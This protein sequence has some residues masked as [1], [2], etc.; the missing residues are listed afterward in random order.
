MF[1]TVSSKPDFVK[2][3]HRILDWWYRSGLVEKYLQKNNKAKK[4]F[5]FFDGPIT[6][7]NPMG[8]HHAWGRT[9]KDLFQ[10]YKNM[11]GYRE[12]FQNGFDCQGLWVEVEVEK[13]AGFNSKKDIEKYGVDKF[14]KACLARVDKYANIQTEQSKR[15]GMFMDWE[16]SYFTNSE[17]NNLYIW[18]FLK[19]IH[20]KGWLYKDKSSATWCP[21]CETGLS[22]HEQADGYKNIDDISVYLKFEIKDRQKEYVLVWTTT[23]WTLSA[24]V[25]LAVNTKFD[26]VKVKLN[27]EI[28][29]LAKESANRLGFKDYKNIDPK[30]LLGLRYESLYDFPAQKG[31]EHKIVEWDLVDPVEGTGV[32]HVAP[33]CGQED[34]E[35]G[36]KLGAAMI[37]PLDEKGYF[38]EGFGTLSNRF[39]HDVTDEV[40]EYLKNKE[41]LLKT[42]IVRHRY[43]H[44]WRC[45]TKCLFRLEDDWFINCTELKPRLKKRASQ[46]NWMPSFAGKRIQDWLDNMGDWMISRKRYYG[47]SLPFYECQCGEI[48][49]VGT[50]EELKKLAVAPG[51]VDKLPSL[52]RPWIDTILIKCPKCGKKV[53]RI[54]D[55][56]DCWLDAGAVPFST[57]KYFEDKA[58]WKKWFPAEFICEMVEQVR[59]WYYSMLVYGTVLEDKVPYLNVLNYM[60]VRD[61]KGERMSKTK[62][63]AIPFD[64]AAEKMGVDVMRW[65]YLSQNP[66]LNMNFGFR[67]GDE[68]RRRFHLLLWNVY[69]FFINYSNIDRWPVKKR[70]PRK[71]SQLDLWTLARLNQTVFEVTEN[72]DDFNFSGA[73]SLVEKFVQDLSTWYLRRSRERMGP[74]AT[75]KNDKN[76]AYAVF[77]HVLLTLV[78]VLAPFIPFLSEEIYQNL[79]GSGGKYKMANSVHLSD[80]PIVRKTKVSDERLIAEMDLVRKICELGHSARKTIGIK[81]RQPMRLI[82]IRTGKAI[83][84]NKQLVRLIKDELNVKEVK[85][86]KG[87]KI[88]V[89]LDSK[90]TPELKA[91]GEAR[92]LVRQVQN[93]R[94]E[95]GCKL[96]EPIT[97]YVSAWPKKFEEYI[98]KKT[99]AKRILP[100]KCLK[101]S[102]G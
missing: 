71:L 45:G 65:M 5:S 18:H 97:I 91:E 64:K 55:V 66:R 14:T 54:P 8:V 38:V 19:I 20:Q 78:K 84:L 37:S 88:S 96:T 23:P 6:A 87:K 57:L 2:M 67:I 33:G 34:Y 22:Q 15:L 62:K 90:I 101:I 36:R 3:E 47:L 74:T 7:N 98:K 46:A 12:R 16:N 29:Y 40:I 39:A 10:R 76:N 52:H 86:A 81:V 68:T 43:P 92:D 24:N 4:T 72:L 95:K 32:V 99:L 31:V 35:L 11:R 73:T 49:I 102:T 69:K 42:E 59:L 94:K 9:L 61:E 27:D 58:Y 13:E 30:T 1:K 28:L 56:G 85:L 48:T 21:R 75:D 83:K 25:L 82:E 26:Y 100:A 51:K 50:K 60:E 41:L 17:T 44:C 63:T 89:K 93:L 77:Y 70:L 79:Q 80:W 53:K